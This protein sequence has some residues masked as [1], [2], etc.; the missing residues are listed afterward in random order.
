MWKL[1]ALATRAF[2][3]GRAALAGFLWPGVRLLRQPRMRLLRKHASVCLARASAW[4]A[5]AAIWLARVGRT[6]IGRLRVSWAL[7]ITKGADF[8]LCSSCFRD[9]GLR[10][11][12]IQI[13]V[14]NESKCPNCMASSL[15][16]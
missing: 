9:Q 2:R 13:G 12:A 16:P 15:R 7:Y 5:L 6:A 1:G 14:H 11:D 8:V 10:L 4:L 3:A